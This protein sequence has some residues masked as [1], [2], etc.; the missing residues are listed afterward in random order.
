MSDDYADQVFPM[1][2]PAGLQYHQRRD[3]NRRKPLFGGPWHEGRFQVASL[4]FATTCEYVVYYAVQEVVG[5]MLLSFSETK[6]GALELA[7]RVLDSVSPQRLQLEREAHAKAC[8]EYDDECEREFRRVIDQTANEHTEIARGKV[9]SIPR[10][11]QQIFDEAEGKC[12]YCAT[13]LT[14][15]GKWHIEH[16]MPKALGGGNEPSNL[17]ASCVPC[18]MKKRDTTDHEFR[19]RLAKETA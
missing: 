4:L 18:N 10:R 6:P 8:R 19:A 16:K 2:R 7:R 11:R 12:H 9:R 17:V 5:E 15:D 14:L 3:S 13:P 1:L